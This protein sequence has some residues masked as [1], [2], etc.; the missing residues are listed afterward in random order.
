MRRATLAVLALA[1]GCGPFD[2]RDDPNY[3][4][5]RHTTPDPRL[6]VAAPAGVAPYNPMSATTAAQATDLNTFA[7]QSR[8]SLPLGQPAGTKS[9]GLAASWSA[10]DKLGVPTRAGPAAK[11][12]VESLA[13]ARREL[14]ARGAADERIE[15]VGDGWLCSCTVPDL[16]NSR[17][18]RYEATDTTALL[19]AAAVLER[20]DAE[21]QGRP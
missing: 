12:R 2:R 13:E 1:A 20:I 3:L 16:A 11:P 14:A 6:A 10:D 19:A 8:G 7:K 18:R 9:A 5:P 15:P 21:R 17:V 4:L